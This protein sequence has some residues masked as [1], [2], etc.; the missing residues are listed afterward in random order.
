MPVHSIIQS[1]SWQNFKSAVLQA[2]F[3]HKP[4]ERGPFLFRGQGSS[5]WPLKSSFD[6]WYHG[7]KSKKGTVSER[8]IKLFEQETEG[9]TIEREI[10]SD[11]P[12][13]LALAQHYGIP[14]RL[15]DW[16]ESPYIAAFFTFSNLKSDVLDKD[17]DHQVAVWCL[18]RRKVDV[19]NSGRWRSSSSRALIRQRAGQKPA[20]MVHPSEGTLRYS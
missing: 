2:L 16:S 8:L 1:E 12:R 6:R 3:D 17:D 4:F 19:W 5:M 18:D 11:E 20:G 13:R 9:L 10:W 7:P 14:T 15:L